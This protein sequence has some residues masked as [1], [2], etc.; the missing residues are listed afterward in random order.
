[1][2]CIKVHPKAEMTSQLHLSHGTKNRK[3]AIVD[4]MT[5]PRCCPLV[6]HVDY[7]H[8]SHVQHRPLLAKMT[9]STKPEVHNVL[10]CCQRMTEPRPPA[11]R[12]ESLL[13]FGHVLFEMCLRTDTQTDRNAHRNTSHPHRG[14]SNEINELTTKTI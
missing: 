9:S 2:L 4:I 14:R 12:A 7:F 10:H 11:T 5:S 6:S 13:T 8:L 3:I 1:M